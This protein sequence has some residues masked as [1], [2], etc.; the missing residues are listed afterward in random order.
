MMF[1]LVYHE[2]NDDH[3]L[4]TAQ[5]QSMP[6]PKKH[7]AKINKLRVLMNADGEPSPDDC[8]SALTE[9]KVR[10]SNDV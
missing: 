1:S 8:D 5:N 9:I 6:N 4:D 2:G 7:L 10:D 3:S